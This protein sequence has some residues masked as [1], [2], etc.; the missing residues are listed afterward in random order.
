[1]I[2]G[3]VGCGGFGAILQDVQEDGYYDQIFALLLPSIRSGYY[4]TGF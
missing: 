3:Y 4:L 1:M 2:L